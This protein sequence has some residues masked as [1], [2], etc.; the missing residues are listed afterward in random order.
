M[1]TL[2]FANRQSVHRLELVNAEN[3][4]WQKGKL[5]LVHLVQA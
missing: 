1:Y 4:V 2:N 5:C 3:R